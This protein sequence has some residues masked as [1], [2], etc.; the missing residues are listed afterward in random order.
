MPEG[1]N[2]YDILGLQRSATDADIK[3]TFRQ[4]AKKF[5]PDVNKDEGAEAKFKEISEA[6]NVL[7]DP[8]K[9][10][11]YDNPQQFRSAFDPEEFFRGFGF[12]GSP[13][14]SRG[15]DIEMQYQISFMDSVKNTERIVTIPKIDSCNACT[16][17]G[18][19]TKST[20]CTH[21]Q[22]RG[23]ISHTQG[24]MTFATNCNSCMGSGKETEYCGNCS[25]AGRIENSQ[26][27]NL[28]IPAGVFTG[29]KLRLPGFG[30]PDPQTAARGDLYINIIVESHP[31]FSREG[32]DIISEV[33]VP[34]QR[35]IL[36][37]TVEAET[38]AGSKSIAIPELTK[39]GD[40]IIEKSAG[41]ALNDGRVGD[42]IFK[43]KHKMPKKLSNDAKELLNKIDSLESLV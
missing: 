3:K 20:S 39:N 11:Q 5:H 13:M 30:G 24:N 6:Y 35:A 21:C 1:R 18:F 10:A 31:V 42:H 40:S 19:S 9:R 41:I 22:G 37:C 32:I 29:N 23:R 17:R 33:N 38:I 12:G 36:G 14:R 8:D 4:L 7:S 25:G 28:K 34:Y 2:Y 16:G 43:I 15:F 27:V 26:Q